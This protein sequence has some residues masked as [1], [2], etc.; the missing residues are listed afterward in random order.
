MKLFKWTRILSVFLTLV[1]VVA[2]AACGEKAATPAENGS[3]AAAAS[4]Q[5]VSGTDTST[6]QAPDPFGKYSPEINVTSVKSLDDTMQKLIGTQ[7]DVLTNNIW[8]NSYKSE[9]GINVSYNWSVPGG[10]FEEK[11]N[12]AISANDLPDIIPATQR[13]L[14]LLVDSGVAL[15]LTKIFKDY[16]APFTMEMMEADNY[17][18]IAQATTDGKLMAL[19]AVSGNRD[20]SNMLWIRNDWLK[21]LNLQAPRTMDDVLKIAEAFTKDDPDKNGKNDTYALALQKGLIDMQ[22]ADINGFMESYH[23]YIGSNAWIKDSSG[24]LVFGGIQPEVKTALSKLAEMYDA[25]QID[26]EF[27]IKDGSKVAESI[28]GGKVGMMYGQHWLAFYPLQDCK[29]KD[30]K[31]DWMPYPITSND[32]KPA[33]TMLNGSATLFYV[34]NKNMKNPE[35]AVK[36]YNYYY[37]KDPALSKDFDPKFHGTGVGQGTVPGE[38]FFWSV[39]RAGYP[40]QNLFIHQQVKKYLETKD[41]TLLENYWIK[42]NVEQNQKYLAGDN[43]FYSAYAWS[44]PNGGESIIDYY[45]QN[46]LMLQNSYVKA[47]TDSM[48]QKGATLKQMR[49]ETFTKIIM[50]ISPI[51][52]FDKYVDQWHKLG[53]DD[54]TN[55]VNAVK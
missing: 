49:D 50:G 52:D 53:G 43:K 2:L 30:P 44:G 32:D 48:T 28:V 29:N 21:N 7:S 36:L 37:A 23:A 26:K 24:K 15:D 18:A 31:S 55:E 27:S 54:I 14:K 6:A 39:M 51:S 20:N 47:D 35:A 17:G 38:N 1:M 5:E 34:V 41:E 25:G 12:V 13:Q 4:T 3:T 45:D 11:L 40:M 9:L 33:M 42:D 16:A 22:M 10:Q 19:P 46:K 8:F